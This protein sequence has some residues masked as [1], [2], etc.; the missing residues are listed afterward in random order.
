MSIVFTT[1]LSAQGGSVSVSSQRCQILTSNEGTPMSDDSQSPL[2]QPDMK[3]P[4]GQSSRSLNEA[5]GAD[6]RWTSYRSKLL[7]VGAAAG[8]LLLLGVSGCAGSSGDSEP[9]ANSSGSSEFQLIPV[10]SAQNQFTPPVAQDASDVPQ[11]ASEQPSEVSAKQVGLY[12]GSEKINVCD[13]TQLKDFLESPE[14]KSM[15]E[16]WAATLGIKYSEIGSSIDKWTSA[17]LRSDTVVTNHGWE[18]GQVTGFPSVLQAGTAVLIDQY[19]EPVTRC[20]CGNPLTPPTYP[21]Y[22]PPSRTPSYTPTYPSN[23]P[24]SPSYTPTYPSEPPTYTGDGWPDFTPRS[25]TV[26][27]RTTTQIKVFTFVNVYQPSQTYEVTA[28][29]DNTSV[30]TSTKPNPSSTYRPSSPSTSRPSPSK[31]SHTPTPTYS[32]YTPTPSNSYQSSTPSHSTG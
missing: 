15:G 7:K 31:T 17:I 16:G 28:G 3:N 13:K 30:P 29:Q 6:V 4:G 24:T 11:V 18:N 19:G 23:T 14:N 9:S 27:K 21:P 32:Y 22:Y 12:G 2:D 5:G 1:T 8:A 20:Y 25:V 26:I 10:N